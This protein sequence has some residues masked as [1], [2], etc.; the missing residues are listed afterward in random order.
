[1]ILNQKQIRFEET[2]EDLTIEKTQ[3]TKSIS[4]LRISL[5]SPTSVSYWDE[6][7]QTVITTT[8]SST[9]RALQAEL[10]TTIADRDNL[11]LKLEA[12]LD[13]IGKTDLALLDK[14]ISNE[15][16]SELGPLKY[17]AETTGKP[18]NEVVNWFLLLIVFV[19]DP[20]A[21]ALVVAANMA[22]AHIRKPE[23]IVIG[24][25]VDTDG[26]PIKEITVDGGEIEVT[27]E[28]TK[29]QM[30]DEDYFSD[31]Q[32]YIKAVAEEPLDNLTYPKTPLNIPTHDPQTGELNPYYKELTDEENP[33]QEEET[34][35]RMD[36]IGQNGN[37]G[38]HYD[39]EEIDDTIE[40][41]LSRLTD[42]TQTLI[43]KEE[44]KDDL[45]IDDDEYVWNEL[46]QRVTNKKKNILRY[47]K[48]GDT[49]II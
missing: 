30:E 32:D 46:G 18:M 6:N 37:D 38:L 16:E 5:S 4:D 41:D 44:V 22:F 17:L 39:E 45:T 24:E 35:K 33:L 12:V 49:P 29:K 10:K 40:E 13:S 43:V 23:D 34:N 42:T 21:I 11:N 25:Y 1:M 19:F 15:A 26:Q 20:L 27:I 3:I 28:P 9:R 14:E 36:I 31:L 48:R 8:S 2:K 7:S 47:T